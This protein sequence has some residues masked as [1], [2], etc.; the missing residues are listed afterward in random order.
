MRNKA[1]KNNNNPECTVQFMLQ[2]YTYFNRGT[3]P[4]EKYNRVRDWNVDLIP[5]F[6]MANGEWRSGAKKYCEWT[7]GC[8]TC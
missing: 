3:K 6:L 7:F 1:K 2:L 4:P 5:K 8:K